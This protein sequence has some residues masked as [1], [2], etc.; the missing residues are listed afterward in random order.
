VVNGAFAAIRKAQELI[1]MSKHH[2]NILV[3]EPQMF[4][5]LSLLPMP[6]WRIALLVQKP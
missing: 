2:E 5:P 1:D 4:V 6:R 3:S